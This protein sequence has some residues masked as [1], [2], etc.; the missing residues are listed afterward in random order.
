MFCI[1]CGRELREG[2]WFCEA[3]GTQ[4]AGE[5]LAS[6]GS[7]IPG[8]TVDRNWNRLQEIAEENRKRKSKWRIITIG[9]SFFLLWRTSKKLLGEV[10]K[11]LEGRS[12]IPELLLTGIASIF[13]SILLLCVL[14]GLI[15]TVKIIKKNYREC[16]HRIQVSDSY[17]LLNALRQMNCPAVEAVSMDEWGNVF[18]KPNMRLRRSRE[19]WNWIYIQVKTEIF[20]S[21]IQLQWTY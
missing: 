6:K 17:G 19:C 10:G 7:S 1:N 18:A 11:I 15:A 4:N 5:R 14:L 13:V 21:G 3:C 8:I 2:V 16:L 9:L 20:W 12:N